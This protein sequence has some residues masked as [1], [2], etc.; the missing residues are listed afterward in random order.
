MTVLS[1]RYADAF[2]YAFTLHRDQ[3]RKGSD[4]PYVTHL[5]AVSGLVLEHGGSEDE[6][7][8]GLLHDAV[9]DQG[10]SPTLAEIRR[11]FGDEVAAIV[12]G[13]SDTDVTPKPPW[14]QRKEDY[15]AHLPYASRSIRLVSVADKLHNA[16]AT[17]AD[18]RR[19]REALWAHFK[20]GRYG[21]LWNYRALIGA[22]R[23]A[24]GEPTQEALVAEL[25]RVVGE[26][27]RL[28]AGK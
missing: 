12:D 11:R 20:G 5:I 16:R 24:A 14:R 21:T 7:I 8:A 27:E 19:V 9:E 17:L 10:G 22:Y 18:Y 4:I 23:S 13:C 28:V 1:D 6:A 2:A 3:V 25:D 15:L 26:L